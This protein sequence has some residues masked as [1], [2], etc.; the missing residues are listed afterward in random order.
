MLSTAINLYENGNYSDAFPIFYKLALQRNSEAQLY[1]GILYESGDG[2][3]KNIEEAKNWYRKAYRQKNLDAGF[4][5]QSLEA[6]TN[7]RC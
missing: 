7:C 4:R 2:I 3:E 5:L 6:G 1:L